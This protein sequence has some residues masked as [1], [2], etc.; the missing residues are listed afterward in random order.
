MRMVNNH[1]DGMPNVYYLASD[2]SS[3]R[4]YETDGLNFFAS[5]KEHRHGQNNI[6]DLWK[7][8]HLG[9]WQTR[10]AT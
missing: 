5:K 3:P 1:L 7:G 8:F 10:S 9:T 4:R 6:I 2:I